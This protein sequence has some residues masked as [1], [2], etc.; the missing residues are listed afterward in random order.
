M[1]SNLLALLSEDAAPRSGTLAENVAYT[2]EEVTVEDHTLYTVAIIPVALNR[3]LDKSRLVLGTI[4][5]AADADPLVWAFSQ[6]INGGSQDFADP[7]IGPMIDQLAAAG[8]WPSD[9]TEAM[10]AI[11]IKTMPRWQKAGVAS[12]P[13][14]EQIK[15]ILLDRKFADAF[16]GIRQQIADGSLSGPDE[17]LAA[18]SSAND[19]IKTSLGV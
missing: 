3:D 13:T 19:Q 5:A 15:R 9:V 8:K 11:G 2:R 7:S 10:H 1:D 4:K 14:E 17:I 12:E 16:V 18:V 6:K